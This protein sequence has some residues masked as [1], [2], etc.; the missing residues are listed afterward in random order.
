MLFTKSDSKSKKIPKILLA[1]YNT[2]TH[3]LVIRGTAHFKRGLE[4]KIFSGAIFLGNVDISVSRTNSRSDN[5]ITLYEWI[6]SKHCNNVRG[7]TVT[8]KYY[9]KNILIN[10]A[11]TQIKSKS[12]YSKILSEAYN[13]QGLVIKNNREIDDFLHQKNKKDSLKKVSIEASSLCNLRCVYCCAS[14]NYNLIDRGNMPLELFT[15]IIETI[16]KTPSINTIQLSGLGEPLLNPLFADMVLKASTPA[17]IK[18][19]IFFT[20]GMCVDEKLCAK[21]SRVEKKMII[22]FSI[23]GDS[24]EENDRL[25][26]GANYLKIRNNIKA[27]LRHTKNNTNIEILINNTLLPD[28]QHINEIPDT[29]KFLFDEFSGIPIYSRRALYFSA[30]SKSHLDKF[31]IKQ[32]IDPCKVFCARPFNETTIRSNGDII[33]CHWDSG[34]E[35]TIG[36]IKNNSLQDIW[37]SRQYEDI[38]DS[39]STQSKFDELKSPCQNC[40]VMNNGCLYTESEDI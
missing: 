16:S 2:K 14:E 33:V 22:Y 34:C 23:D 5:T 30:L 11:D 19:L 15:K 25:R 13:K 4:I 32:V 20:N 40:H 17:N 8:I 27:L 29:P 3:Q 35:L 1:D 38:R 26:K 28:K 18:R 21:L 37:L 9:Y 36:N 39:M 12:Y 24:P 31:N 6:F 7:N 10:K